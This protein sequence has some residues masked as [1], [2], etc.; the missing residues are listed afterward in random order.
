M[1]VRIPTFP[2]TF[3]TSHGLLNSVM[4]ISPKMLTTTGFWVKMVWCF[5]KIWTFNFFH[6]SLFMCIF[7]CSASQSPVPHRVCSDMME[8]ASKV[9]LSQ[10][11]T[12]LIRPWTCR[13]VWAEGSR[14]MEA[15][16][17]WVGCCA[18]RVN[19]DIRSR[20]WLTLYGTRNLMEMKLVIA[21]VCDCTIASQHCETRFSTVVSS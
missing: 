11:A 5:V 2:A 8:E 19:T 9:A 14:F 13:L 3:A 7:S 15:L 6:L 10:L 16:N 1:P 4:I 20:S 12:N 17:P 21:L 18:P